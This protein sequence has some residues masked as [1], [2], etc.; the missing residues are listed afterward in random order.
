MMN[1][2]IDSGKDKWFF[3]LK[4]FAVTVTAQAGDQL[5]EASGEF[6]V[7]RVQD[8]TSPK[9]LRATTAAMREEILS[10]RVMKMTRASS[11]S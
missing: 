4:Y 1:E 8:R 11:T 10:R 2:F 6:A 5:A 9:A 7:S 3:I